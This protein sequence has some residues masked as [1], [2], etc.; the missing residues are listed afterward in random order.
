MNGS[1]PS[2]K[3]QN[4]RSTF[5]LL[6]TVLAIVDILCIITFLG[7]N[8]NHNIYIM[9][10]FLFVTVDYSVLKV[11]DVTISNKFLLYVSAYVWFPVKNVL[12]TL[13]SYLIVAISVERYL[14]VCR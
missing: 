7:W 9:I 4:Q 2:S 6:L 5:S 8:Y 11:W 10:F 12:L 3:F 14:A 1:F 13:E